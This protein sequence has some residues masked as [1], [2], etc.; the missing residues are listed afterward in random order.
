MVESFTALGVLAGSVL[1]T[2]M[3]PA[4]RRTGLIF[5]ATGF[6]FAG[7]IIQSLT[8]R[9]WLWCAAAF[10]CYVPAAV[11]NVNM[12]VLMRE[13]VPTE[14]QGRVFSAKSTLQNFTIPPALLL[15]G[16][17]AD[18]VFEPFMGK[19][20]PVQRIL[21]GFFGAGKGSG[22][23]VMLFIVGIAGMAASFTRLRK[24]VYR[25]LDR[26]ETEALRAKPNGGNRNGQS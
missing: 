14:M 7:N 5:I 19:D 13:N 6:V 25:E 22:I 15:G 23:G 11:M 20:S 17:L 16:L 8:S 21:S 2:M 18:T 1:A 12:D 10:G 4:K 24:P 9:P 26:T 3:K